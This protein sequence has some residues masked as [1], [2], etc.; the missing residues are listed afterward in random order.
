MTRDEIINDLVREMMYED[1]Y[2]EYNE[3]M[4]KALQIYENMFKEEEGGI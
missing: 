1:E 3:A 2:L 4:D